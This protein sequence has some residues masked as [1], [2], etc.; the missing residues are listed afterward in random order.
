MFVV[1]QKPGEEA[2]PQQ[3]VLIVF[4]CMGCHTV[5]A[6][7]EYSIQFYDSI[8]AAMKSRPIAPCRSCNGNYGEPITGLC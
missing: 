8:D 7:D 3:R 5:F 4:H 1:I 2:R 6:S